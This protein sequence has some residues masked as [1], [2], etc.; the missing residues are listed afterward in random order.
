MDEQEFRK[1]NR[2][3]EKQKTYGVNLMASDILYMKNPNNGQSAEAPVGY[4]WTTLAFGFF[5]ALFRSDWKWAVI[6]FLLACLTGG[7]SCV[8]FS[9]IY[10]KL[11]LKELIKGGYVA[12]SSKSGSVESAVTAAGFPVPALA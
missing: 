8:V 3:F 12:E 7:L 5:P 10:N 11:Y 1:V 2:I 9:F 6:Q 4:S